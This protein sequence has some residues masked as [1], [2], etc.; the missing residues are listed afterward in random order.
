VATVLAWSR[1]HAPTQHVVKPTV[2]NLVLW[3]SVYIEKDHIHVDAIRVGLFGNVVVT[4]GGSVQRFISEKDLPELDPASVLGTDIQRFMDFSDG[5]VAYDPEQKNVLGDIRYSMLPTSTRPL[6]GIVLDPDKP[7][8]HADY[9]FFRDASKKVR[10][11]FLNL[12]TG[13]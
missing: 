3:R 4:T 5:Y 8:Q 11:V 12:L 13:H 7:G 2:A 6:W 10:Q 9:R 1:G